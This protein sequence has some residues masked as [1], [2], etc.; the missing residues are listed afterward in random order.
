MIFNKA[1]FDSVFE[2]GQSYQL[3]VTNQTNLKVNYYTLISAVFHF[4]FQLPALC[5]SQNGMPIFDA[6]Y[7]NLHIETHPYVSYTMGLFSAPIFLICFFIPACFTKEDNWYNR[8]SLILLPISSVIIATVTMGYAGICVRYNL[9]IFPIMAFS[10]TIT[11]A[12]PVS[13]T[14]L[15]LPTIA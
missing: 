6:S 8:I 9:D 15:T 14:H 7:L 1:R 3:T 13:Y 10:T 5:N 11:I 4:Y 12:K 2:F